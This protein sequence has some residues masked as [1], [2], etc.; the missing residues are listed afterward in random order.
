M[1]AWKA[2]TSVVCDISG[3]R[4]QS[5]LVCDDLPGLVVH[6][7]PH[8]RDRWNVA[9]ERTGLAILR[10]F[11]SANAAKAAARR[12]GPIAPWSRKN[13][14]SILRVRPRLR[15]TLKKRFPR[16]YMGASR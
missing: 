13:A 9:H 11:R 6:L 2:R 4:L 5:C 3:F 1:A 12:L 16:R 8:S 14:K 15:Q 10:D 7:A